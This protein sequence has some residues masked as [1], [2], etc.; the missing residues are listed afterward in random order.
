MF[1]MQINSNVRMNHSLFSHLI[2]ITFKILQ[3]ISYL[4][5]FSL[6]EN[7]DEKFEK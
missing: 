2:S 7:L 6:F 4:S 5:K 3:K 1:F